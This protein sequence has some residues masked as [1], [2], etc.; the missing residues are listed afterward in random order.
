MPCVFAIILHDLLSVT[1]YIYSFLPDF[2]KF[3]VKEL[4][5]SGFE[6][7]LRQMYDYLFLLP[8]I[9]CP[10]KVIMCRNEVWKIRKRTHPSRSCKAA[11][12]RFVKCGL[13]LSS[14]KMTLVSS[15]K[16]FRVRIIYF[17]VTKLAA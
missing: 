10:Q 8:V 6:A 1:Q 3:D 4:F 11:F 15:I 2:V 9:I 13:A 14:R 5:H 12:T 7:L 16:P 17:D